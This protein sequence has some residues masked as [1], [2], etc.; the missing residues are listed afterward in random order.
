[1]KSLSRANF[2]W[3]TVLLAA[4]MLSTRVGHVGDSLHLPD[5]SMAVF[6]LGGLYLRRNFAFV[7]Y[8]ALA[9]SIDWAVITYAGVSNFCVTAAYPFLV[10]AYAAL[11][12]GGKICTNWLGRNALSFAGTLGVALIGSSVSFAI[13]S[14]SFYWLGGRIA[15][16]SVAGCIEDIWRWGPTF[17]GVTAG[18]VAAGLLLHAV[19][20]TWSRRLPH[21]KQTA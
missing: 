20:L 19:A 15:H 17:V 12:Y 10:P 1:M 2:V 13:S 16:P 14:S 6:F 4:L 7:G 5:A 8:M 21:A 11:W 18:Y 9:V 3:T